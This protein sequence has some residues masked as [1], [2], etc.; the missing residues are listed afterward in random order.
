[1]LLS[2]LDAIRRRLGSG[3]TEAQRLGAKGESAA[4]RFL[5][6]SGYRVL[7]RNLRLSFGEA[8]LVCL[9]PDRETIVIVE[10]KT[11]LATPGMIAPEVNI[12]PQKQRKLAAIARRIA[13]DN[14]WTQRPLR[15]D[16]VAVEWPLGQGSP[17]IRH[18][19]GAIGQARP[20]G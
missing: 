12:T 13:K 10:V 17:V 18:H 5:K 8:D 11:R 16:A 1:M 4:A 9:A 7:A 20:A 14:A 15:I 19:A 2:A 6:R 3:R